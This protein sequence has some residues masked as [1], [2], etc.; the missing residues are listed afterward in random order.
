MYAVIHMHMNMSQRQ[1]S[2][3]R[4]DYRPNQRIRSPCFY[5]NL[6]ARYFDFYYGRNDS[7]SNYSTER[8]LEFTA[9]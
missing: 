5:F 1:P 8:K 9:K 3:R 6:Y 7:M 2:K 4:N